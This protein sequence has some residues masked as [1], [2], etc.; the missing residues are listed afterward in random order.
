MKQET[1]KELVE[2]ILISKNLSDEE[3]FELIDMLVR[4]INNRIHG[5]SKDIQEKQFKRLV[6]PLFENYIGDWI[7]NY[8]DL[9]VMINQ[10]I[11]YRKGEKE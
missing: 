8:D 7:A 6:K 3:V 5:N 9:D 4:Y 1:I 2:W 10:Y 11:S